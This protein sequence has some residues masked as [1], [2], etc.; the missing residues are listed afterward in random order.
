MGK[1]EVSDR[2]IGEK[3]P[4]SWLGLFDHN[5]ID[6]VNY[7]FTDV[8]HGFGILIDVLP[9]NHHDRILRGREKLCQ[10]PITT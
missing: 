1:S 3:M 8:Q 7:V 2:M 5:G 10:H 6:D 9:L 4:G